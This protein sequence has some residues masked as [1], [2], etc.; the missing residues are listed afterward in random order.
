M[1]VRRYLTE[2]VTISHTIVVEIMYSVLVSEG[3]CLGKDPQHAH[4]SN[5]T[6]RPFLSLS[7]G[8]DDYL[9]ENIFYV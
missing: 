8:H 9:M 2:L 1:G 4:L 6:V 3:R 5:S 7:L